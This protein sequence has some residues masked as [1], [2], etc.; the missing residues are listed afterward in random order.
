MGGGGRAASGPPV[1]FLGGANSQS[2]RGRES[3]P[4][5]KGGRLEASSGL[6][7]GKMNCRREDGII[8]TPSCLLILS[9]AR[10]RHLPL[11][12]CGAGGRASE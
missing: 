2:G 8:C 12:S 4:L 11:L 3:E 9:P 7:M 10:R 6:L 5:W 1:L